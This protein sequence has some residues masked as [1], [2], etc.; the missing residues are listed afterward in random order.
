[1]NWKRAM[2]LEWNRWDHFA[3]TVERKWDRFTHPFRRTLEFVP[4]LYQYGKILWT[5]YEGDYAEIYALLQLKF[6][7]MADAIEGRKTTIGWEKQVKELR[8]GQALLERLLN[9][10]YCYNLYEE[11]NKK[12]D[13]L[14]G[15]RRIRAGCL[16][17]RSDEEIKEFRKIWGHEEYLKKQDLEYLTH[18]IKKHINTWWD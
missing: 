8:T 7:R 11:H 10:D 3:D 4:A 2:K 14:L 5:D 15:P 18:L 1:M 17:P 9:D 6:K 16:R 12:W 13:D